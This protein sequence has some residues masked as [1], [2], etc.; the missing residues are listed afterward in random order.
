VRIVPAAALAGASLL[1][2]LARPAAAAPPDPSYIFTQM[3]DEVSG[4]V[5]A[6]APFQAKADGGRKVR[7]VVG[8]VSNDSDDEGVRVD[9][10]YNEIRNQIVASGSV[11]LFDRGDLDADLIISP[12]L[13]S[14]RH[15]DPHGR[16][17]YCFTLQLTLTS[18]SGEFVAAESATRCR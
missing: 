11:R 9:D 3:A 6:S 4:K 14:E 2:A 13:T 8:D 7:I 1:M 17:E 12:Q 5:L 18:V 10:I 15:L 16:R